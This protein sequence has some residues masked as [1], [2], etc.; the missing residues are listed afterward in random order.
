MRWSLIEAD[1]GAHG[2]LLHAFRQVANVH[3]DVAVFIVARDEAE[4]NYKAALGENPREL[5]KTQIIRLMSLIAEKIYVGK[6]DDQ[7]GTRRLEH[8]VQSGEDVPERHLRAFRMAKEEILYCWLGYIGQVTEHHLVSIGRT[9]HRER[10]FQYPFP[11]QLWINIGNFIENLARLPMW[12]DRA[13]SS[14]VF[15][16]KQTYAF[17][18]TIFE[19]GTSPTGQKVMTSGLNIMEMIKA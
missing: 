4:A 14:T 18:Q 7:I 17:W 8:K 19:N 1:Q 11:E 15:G 9:V 10:L 16:G 6:Y 3:E 2:Q 5:E 12:V 13:Q